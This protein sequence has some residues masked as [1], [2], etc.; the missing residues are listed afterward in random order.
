M[1]EGKIKMEVVV[2]PVFLQMVIMQDSNNCCG[3]VNWNGPNTTVY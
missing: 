1:S 2:C 3:K